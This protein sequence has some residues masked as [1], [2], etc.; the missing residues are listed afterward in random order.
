MILYLQMFESLLYVAYICLA[1]FWAVAIYK[2]FYAFRHFKIKNPVVSTELLDKLPSVT[3]CI[4]ARNETHAMTECLERV[5][6]STYPKLEVIVMDD[7]SADDTSV[8]IKSFAHAGVRFVEGVKLPQGWLGKNHALQRL[9]KEASGSYI[10]FMDV[11]TRIKP[12]TIE[13]LVAYA[14]QQKAKMVSVMPRREDGWRASVLLSPLRYLWELMF[15]RQESPA[16]SSNA[17]LIDRKVLV[18]N[19]GFERYKDAIQPESR[20]SNLLMSKGK[21]RFLIGSHDLGV[22][23]EK[24]WSSQASTSVRLL[25]PL[26]RSNLLISLVA[27]FD[28]ILLLLPL[29]VI[30]VSLF[31]GIGVHTVI[32]SV[33]YALFAIFYAIYARKVWH[34]GWIAAGFIW[35]IIALQEAALV[36]VSAVKY[37]SGGVT[38]KGRPVREPRT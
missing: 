32:A 25:F 30:L 38:W 15:H 13:K 36:I 35:P 19:D 5:V 1:G 26:L 9:Y 17:W 2:L 4:P 21:Y 33:L 24:K 20:Y 22:A 11:D 7:S 31:Y 29:I 23:Y 8:I 6:A 18:D 27:V 3:V 12:E 37:V 16:T 10:F 28:L 34:R 14:T